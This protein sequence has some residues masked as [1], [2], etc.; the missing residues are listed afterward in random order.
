MQHRCK[1]PGRGCDPQGRGPMVGRGTGKTGDPKLDRPAGRLWWPQCPCSGSCTSPPSTPGPPTCSWKAPGDSHTHRQA[2][3]PPPGWHTPSGKSRH[4]GGTWNI[5][6]VKHRPK[7]LEKPT[8][9]AGR[10][11]CAVEWRWEHRR[12]NLRGNLR[13]IDE[14]SHETE[15]AG[16]KNCSTAKESSPPGKKKTVTTA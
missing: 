3:P 10:P 11:P 8:L 13:C 7:K 5:D 9:R 2:R 6:K 14:P 16:R 12:S 1:S 4:Q 15:S